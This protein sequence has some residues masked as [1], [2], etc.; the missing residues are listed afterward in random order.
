[1]AALYFAL[2]LRSAYL[3]TFGARPPLVLWT[4]FA[5]ETAPT[6]VWLATP[7]TVVAV[8]WTVDRLDRSKHPAEAYRLLC[9]RL[10][11]LIDHV[12][13]VYPPGALAAAQCDLEASGGPPPPLPVP[14]AYIP[15][16]WFPAEACRA[17][18][19]RYCGRSANN[20]GADINP[21]LPDPQGFA[22]EDAD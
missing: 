12:D 16:G 4:V 18:L 20:S 14:E 10:R 21:S 9:D 3:P 19:D 8:S 22:E 7:R 1:M 15:P 13:A 2:N 11:R 5:G 17:W 6:A